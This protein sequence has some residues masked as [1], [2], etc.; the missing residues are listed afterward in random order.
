MTTYWAESE[1]TISQEMKGKIW[2]RRKKK[3]RPAM[4]GQERWGRLNM[5]LRAQGMMTYACL[6]K[7]EVCLFFFAIISMYFWGVGIYEP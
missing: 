6:Q 3:Y 5:C 7:A 4:P 1:G 2:H